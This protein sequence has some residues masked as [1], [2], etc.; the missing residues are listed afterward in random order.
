VI[1]TVFIKLFLNR[2]LPTLENVVPGASPRGPSPEAQ[3]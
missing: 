3:A 1:L 2:D